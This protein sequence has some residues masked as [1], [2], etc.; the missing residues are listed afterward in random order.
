MSFPHLH[1]DPPLTPDLTAFLE[2]QE[3][4]VGIF[5]CSVVSEPLATLVL[6]HNGLVLASTQGE[7]DHSSRFSVFSTPN[8]LNLEIRNLGPA[9]SGEYTCSATNSLG[10][11]SSTLGFHAKG[12]TG[13]G[14]GCGVV[15]VKGG[16]RRLALAFLLGVP[17]T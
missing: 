13:M 1:T 3:G 17:R 7:G 8:S 15:L 5:H 9:D 12:K 6:S 2:T 10:N 16:R 4:L 14:R 11:S